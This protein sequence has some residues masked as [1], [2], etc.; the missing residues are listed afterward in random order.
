[1]ARLKDPE[2]DDLHWVLAPQASMRQILAVHEQYYIEKVLAKIPAAGRAEFEASGTVISAQSEDAIW[3]A[4]GAV[5]AAVDAIAGGRAGNAFCAIRPPG[6]HAKKAQTSGFCFFNNVAVG[7]RHLQKTHGPCKVAVIDFDVHH[8][9]GTQAL[10]EKDP[11]IFFASIHQGN[12]FPKTGPMG[13]SELGNVINI[14]VARRFSGDDFLAALRDRVL[15]P[16]KA[17]GPEFIFL[18]AGFDAHLADPIGDLALGS[19]DFGRLTRAILD[20]ARTTSDGRV[21]SVLEGGYAPGAVAAGAAAHVAEMITAATR[22][23]PQNIGEFG[24]P[25]VMT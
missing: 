19:K 13:V 14:P 7:V 2:F 3:R 17:F 8:G 12:I 20:I 4:P 25:K 23:P 6:H 5:C 9:N 18:S 24:Y 10:L 16:M 22:K 1:M 15:P 21:V 11:D